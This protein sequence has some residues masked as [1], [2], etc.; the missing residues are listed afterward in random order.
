MPAELFEEFQSHLEAEHRQKE[1]KEMGPR[2]K[3]YLSFWNRCI[4][5][6]YN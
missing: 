5:E 6:S 4:F 1:Q 3:A 2:V